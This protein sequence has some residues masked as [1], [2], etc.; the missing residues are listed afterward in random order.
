MSSNDLFDELKKTKCKK[1][2]PFTEAFC[3]R[4][5]NNIELYLGGYRS[6]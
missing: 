6:N 2:S 4:K 1:K 3:G 5:V